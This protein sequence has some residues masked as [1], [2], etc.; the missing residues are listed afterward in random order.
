MKQPVVYFL[1]SGRNGTLYIGVTSNL[2]QRVFEHNTDVH[3]GFTKQHGVHL[4]VYVEMHGTMIEAIEREKALNKWNRAWK[5]DLIEKHNPAWRD[6][7]E[8]IV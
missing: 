6:L 2:R 7:Y 8:D 3:D 5:I 4:L 1:A